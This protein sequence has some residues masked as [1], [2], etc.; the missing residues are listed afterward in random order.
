MAPH[1]PWVFLLIAIVTPPN[2][3]AEKKSKS[4]V[5]GSKRWFT[6]PWQ[7][8]LN[9]TYANILRNMSGPW[10]FM[11]NGT[12]YLHSSSIKYTN[13]TCIQAKT[14]EKNETARTFTHEVNVGME[15]NGNKNCVVIEDTLAS[16]SVT[17]CDA[18]KNGVALHRVYFTYK[19]F[20]GSRG[21]TYYVT[22]YTFLLT[23]RHCAVVVKNK[24]KL[25]EAAVQTMELWVNNRFSKNI[26]P[27]EAQFREVCNCARNRTCSLNIVPGKMRIFKNIQVRFRDSELR[28]VLATRNRTSCFPR[29][30]LFTSRH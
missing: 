15:Y 13:V 7:K 4:T 27:C 24:Q 14:V 9:V 3:A 19:R 16:C 20:E 23:T 8:S 2:F 30:F 1:G 10:Q 25:N 21:D 6:T 26:M 5:V 12:I 22:N 11:T 28:E 29:S 17:K 18:C